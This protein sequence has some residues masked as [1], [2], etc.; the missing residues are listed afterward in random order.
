MFLSLMQDILKHMKASLSK[1]SGAFLYCVKLFCCRTVLP[2]LSHLNFPIAAKKSIT[3]WWLHHL[4]KIMWMRSGQF[5]WR[6]RVSHKS[7]L[8]ICTCWQS[9]ERGLGNWKDVK[10][11]TCLWLPCVDPCKVCSGEEISAVV[12]CSVLRAWINTAP[13]S[14]RCTNSIKQF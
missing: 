1:L 3:I 2:R 5:L 13:H 12:C 14:A 11:A 7:Q 9:Q 10:T 4:S 8:I 6:V